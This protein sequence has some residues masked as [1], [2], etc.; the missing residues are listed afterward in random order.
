M[1]FYAR[2][3]KVSFAR[4][5]VLLEQLGL[6]EH[7]KKAVP[8]LSGGLKQ[9]L[10]LAIALL[11]DPPV[12]LLDEPTASLDA[13][14][15]HDY[16]TLLASLRRDGKTI[17]FASHRIEELQAL[18]DRVV[19]LENGELVEITTPE[20]IR[21]KLLS[22]YE[23]TLWVSDRNAALNQLLQSGLSAHLNGRGTVVVQVPA[24]NKA[25]PMQLLSE[26]GITVLDFEMEQR[27]SW[28]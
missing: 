28:N 11:S 17:I 19:V 13:R 15:R 5:P 18:A 4:I 12:L 26:Q 1:E 20:A 3:K 14:A 24:A 27:Q 25:Y 16:L 2:I 23:L 7:A 9:R 6:V 21:S 8:A 22:D 10:A